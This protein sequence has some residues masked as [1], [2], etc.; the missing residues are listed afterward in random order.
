MKFL[1]VFLIGFGAFCFGQETETTERPKVFRRLIPA[2]VLRGKTFKKKI[3]FIY[4]LLMATT[5]EN[6]FPPPLQINYVNTKKFF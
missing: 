1:I 6:L 4:S 2:D 5:G 3:F